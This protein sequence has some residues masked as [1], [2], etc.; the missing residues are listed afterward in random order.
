MTESMDQPG[1]RK[2]ARLRLK[3]AMLSLAVLTFLLLAELGLRI[4]WHNPYRYDDPDHL[5]LLRIS[6]PGRHFILNRS[7]ISKDPAIID[8]RVNER[9]YIYPVHQFDN[10]NV[11]IAF[12]GGSTTEL[13]SV[14]E[15]SRFPAYI[16]TLLAKRGLK[17]NTLNGGRSLTT[18]HDA[19][20]ILI[21]HLID[22]RPDVV[23]FMEAVSDIGVLGRDG[24]YRRS[25]SLPPSFSPIITWTMQR[26]S[27]LS[28]LAGA[29]RA[30]ATIQLAPANIVPAGNAFAPRIQK[31]VPVEEFAKRLRVFVRASKAFGITPVLMTQPF[32]NM[33]NNLTPDWVDATQQYVFNGA[34]R[35]VG[36]EEDVVVIDLA[37]HFLESVP[38]RDA[39]MAYFYDGIHVTDRGSQEEAS[40]IVQRLAETILAPKLASKQSRPAAESRSGSDDKQ[41]TGH[42][43]TLVKH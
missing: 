28:Y 25:M 22:D 42:E 21:N 9:G 5:I 10:P 18:I 34:T 8:F 1:V 43:P 7:L 20:N 26:A 40:Y 2:P 13:F 24:S 23:V 19:L 6:T 4:F 11:T 15:P 27:S 16:S 3:L 14:D 33:R 36:R 37:R 35:T 39:P 17:V 12:L 38:D 29:L 31:P 41:A 32:A 30:V